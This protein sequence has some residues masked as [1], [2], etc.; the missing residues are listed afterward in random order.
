MLA[1]LYTDDIETDIKRQE[2]NL[3]KARIQYNQLKAANASKYD[4][5]KAI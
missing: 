3:Q 4:L 5:Q 2:L 1:E